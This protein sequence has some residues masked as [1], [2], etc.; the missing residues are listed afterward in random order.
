MTVFVERRL[1]CELLRNRVSRS[2]QVI[3]PM[4]MRRAAPMPVEVPVSRKHRG[5][6]SQTSLI[7]LCRRMSWK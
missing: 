2:G 6:A 4:P 5:L 7:A 1:E 3:M